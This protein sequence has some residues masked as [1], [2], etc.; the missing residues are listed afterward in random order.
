[1]IDLLKGALPFLGVLFGGMLSTPWG[2]AVGGV[3][4]LGLGF[5]A[6]FLWKKWKEFK[7]N[8]AND[9]SNQ[10]SVNDQTNTIN[11]NQQQNINDQSDIKKSEDDK[12]Q[13]KK[14]IA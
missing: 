1:M 3:L 8:V 13:A 11:Q 7:A 2:A 6:W 4:L 10:N 5:G 14:P 12:E 9:I